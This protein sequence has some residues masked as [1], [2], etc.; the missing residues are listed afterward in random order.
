MWANSVWGLFGLSASCVLTMLGLNPDSPWQSLLLFG[1]VFFLIG[2]LGVLSW[3]LRHETNRGKVAALV[4]HPMKALRL[5]EP[6]HVIILGLAIALGG[7]VWQMRKPTLWQKPEAVESAP[8]EKKKLSQVAFNNRH[9]ALSNLYGIVNGPLRDA[10][11][12]AQQIQ[13]NITAQSSITLDRLNEVENFYSQL[14][15]ACAAL[16]N[17]VRSVEAYSDISGMDWSC[18]S[19]NEKTKAL[20]ASMRY[21][22]AGAKG[23]AMWGSDPPQQWKAAIVG[24]SEWIDKTK[25]AVRAK[26][27]E[28]D[29]AE[30]VSDTGTPATLQT[31]PG[32]PRTV[33]LN[34]VRFPY[35]G[36]DVPLEIAGVAADSFSSLKI[37]V[38]TTSGGVALR[39]LG[40]PELTFIA[41]FKDIVKGQRINAPLA[42]PAEGTTEFYW[43]KG[44]DR[45]PIEM[46][47]S[48]RVVIYAPP[49]KLPQ[50]KYLMIIHGLEH[51][52][53]LPVSGDMLDGIGRMIVENPK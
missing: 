41:E 18:Y 14:T 32:S 8:I 5:I 49:E 25:Q 16:S 1:A 11:T 2:S 39:S 6:T 13:P 22:L 21:F 40:N 31:N 47:N 44:K 27:S 10:I 46:V 20:I 26:M 9:R 29:L 17:E 28:D 52:P 42:F 23:Q 37:Y 50:Y 33:F 48:V 35:G 24:F 3:P 51:Q 4:V 45:R 34:D 43:G 36:G 38:E 19:I 30:I 53:F 12:T 7:V 15:A